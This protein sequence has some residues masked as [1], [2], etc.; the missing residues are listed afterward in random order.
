MTTALAKKKTASPKTPNSQ[1]TTKSTKSTKTVT[2]PAVPSQPRRLRRRSV[3]KKDKK[4]GFFSCCTKKR[5][6]KR[7]KSKKTKTG[8][9]LARSPAAKKP[10]GTKSSKKSTKSTKSAK[11]STKEKPKTSA[12]PLASHQKISDKQKKLESEPVPVGIPKAVP[13]RSSSNEPLASPPQ[14]QTLTSSQASTTTPI[15]ASTAGTTTESMVTAPLPPP[16][17]A[18]SNLAPPQEV[19]GYSSESHPSP[20]G[21]DSEGSGT[22]RTDKKYSKDSTPEEEDFG[23]RYQSAAY[24]SHKFVMTQFVKDD[25]R[26]RRWTYEDSIP[27]AMESNMKHMLKLASARISVCRNDREKRCELLKELKELEHILDF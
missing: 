25:C 3:Q 8:K 18:A 24:P 19:K 22:K 20:I 9:K 7:S 27:L 13:L 1:V 21:K 16:G 26:V 15:L 5:K 10:T 14:Q 11:K 23:H 12:V 2:K 6:A 17:Y 4:K